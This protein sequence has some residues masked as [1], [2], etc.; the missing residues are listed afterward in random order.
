METLNHDDIRK[1]GSVVYVEVSWVHVGTFVPP[2]WLL[3]L[4]ECL[5]GQQDY[6]AEQLSK[7]LCDQKYGKRCQPSPS[8][9]DEVSPRASSSGSSKTATILVQAIL[10]APYLEIMEQA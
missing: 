6:T 9:K 10:K 5:W 3:S 4:F 2:H 7:Q 8:V 1:N